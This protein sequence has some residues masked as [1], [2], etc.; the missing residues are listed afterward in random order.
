MIDRS[1]RTGFRSNE[2]G[3]RPAAAQAVPAFVF[4]RACDELQRVG[5]GL[6]ARMGVGPGLTIVQSAKAEE[7]IEELQSAALAG[8]VKFRAQKSSEYPTGRHKEVDPLYFSEQR[9]FEWY[10]DKT[11]SLDLSKSDHAPRSPYSTEDWYDV[12]LD[13]DAFLLLLR[14]MDARGKTKDLQ[15]G[16]DRATQCEPIPAR[17]VDR[18]TQQ[19]YAVIGGGP[20]FRKAGRYPLYPLHQC[21]FDRGG[22]EV[23][24]VPRCA[25]PAPPTTPANLAPRRPHQPPTRIQQVA[26]AASRRRQRVGP[27]AGRS[28]DQ[29]RWENLEKELSKK[30]SRKR[31]WRS[32]AQPARAGRS[33][34]GARRSAPPPRT[35]NGANLRQPRCSM[36]KHR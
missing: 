18:Q 9:G 21:G 31:N 26:T 25:R 33:A 4:G 7:L 11:W 6:A 22:I 35:G 5:L 15:H 8:R 34:G 27:I 2:V 29:R 36:L 20:G 12:H 1:P 19:E 23:D 13:R 16:V 30:N 14:D 24:P 28:A 17:R 32:A 10:C 3:R